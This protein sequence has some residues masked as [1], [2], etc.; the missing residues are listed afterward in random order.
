MLIL[1]LLAR[2]N[3]ICCQCQFLILLNISEQKPLIVPTAIRQ[4]PKLPV[5]KY[6]GSA[7]LLSFKFHQALDID[8]YI[9]SICQTIKMEQ[10][11]SSNRKSLSLRQNIILPKPADISSHLQQILLQLDYL[12]ADLLCQDLCLS[13]FYCHVKIDM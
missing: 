12:H 5:A 1:L 4:L 6:S 10:L 7:S 11:L 9:F 13:F 3:F 2:T 8:I